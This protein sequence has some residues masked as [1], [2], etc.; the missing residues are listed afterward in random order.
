MCPFCSG[1][2]CGS[3]LSSDR[4]KLCRCGG[5]AALSSATELRQPKVPSWEG[6]H[7]QFWISHYICSALPE[8]TR[9]QH[10]PAPLGQHSL[11]LHPSLPA[12]PQSLQQCWGSPS[13]GLGS[14]PSLSDQHMVSGSFQSPAV[15]CWAGGMRKAWTLSSLQGGSPFNPTW[16]LTCEQDST[17][18]SPSAQRDP[19]SSPWARSIQTCTRLTEYYI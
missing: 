13:W 8:D 12:Q 9:A 6:Q 16:T 4:L 18:Q 1:E 2:S 5:A 17:Q 19:L 14:H 3:W 10:L 11:P 7:R 15:P